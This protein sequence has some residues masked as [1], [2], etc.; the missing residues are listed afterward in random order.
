MN[1]PKVLLTSLWLGLAPALLY[2]QPMAL[3]KPAPPPAGLSSVPVAAQSGIYATLGRDDSHY[4]VRAVG[5]GFHADNPQHALAADFTAQGLE[6]RIGK[7]RWVLALRAYGYGNS[8]RSVSTAAPQASANR[9]EYRRGAL[10]EWYVNGPVGL[11]QG[12]TLNEPPGR[13]NGQ[14]LTITAALS[15]DLTVAVEQDGKALMMAK[16]DGHAV[17]RYTGLTAYDAKGRELR[18]W[19][20]LRGE[21][22]LVRVDDSDAHYPLVIDPFVQRAKLTASDGAANDNF[23]ISVGV[24]ADGNT[25]VA[26]SWHANA[27]QGA[28]YLFVKPAS[29]WATTTETAKLTASDG[30]TNDFFGFSVALSGDS[31]TVVVGAFDA[32]TALGS[33]GAGYVFVK[34]ASGWVTTTETAKLTASDGAGGDQFGGSVAVSGAGDTIVGGAS[35]AKIGSNANQGAAYLFVKP[36][37]GWATTTETAKL[38][39]SDGAANDFFGSSAA[40]IGDGSTAVVGAQA[41]I[42]PIQG[43]G[44]GYVFVKPASGWVTTTETAKLTASDGAKNDGFGSSVAVNGDGNTMV[45]GA[46]DA[47]LG[48]NSGQGAAYV[49]I[50]PVSGWATNMVFTAKLTAS[51]GT[52][53]DRFGITVAVSGDGNT[54][55]VGAL[56]ASVGSNSSQGAAYLFVKPASGWATTTE[57][58]KLTASDGAANDS[59]GISVGISA[60]GNTA[61]V[62]SR[63]ATIGS[64][65]SQGAAY[66]FSLNQAATTTTLASSAN[67]STFGQS[68][69]FTA[70][71]SSTAGTPTGTVTFKDG[72]STLGTGTLNGSAQ[73]A[74]SIAALTAGTHT[75]TAAY[76]GDTNF[77]T[78]TSG[79]LTQTVNQASTTTTLIS[80]PNPSFV[81]QSVTFT[82]TVSSSTGAIAT[83]TVTFRRGSTVLGTATLN[84]AGQATFATSTL[85]AGNH[86]ASAVYAGSA[87]F[88]RST[89]TSITQVVQKNPT[90]T[91]LTSSLNPSSKGQTVSFTASVSS[92]AGGTPTG[93]VTFKNGSNN[94]GSAT[95]DALGQAT[96]STSLLQR[97]THNI[98]SKYHGDANFASSTSATLVQTVN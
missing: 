93:T 91:S 34:P 11:E 87:N 18:S 19:L 77:T 55:L 68:V 4:Q 16:P 46:F 35:G 97:G 95:L 31:S 23:G 96:F 85:R 41:T 32:S 14:P 52:A 47:T 83:G 36:A 43:Q 60:G 86:T 88:A 17:L 29:G 3:R 58:A 90:T 49:F 42:G 78:S 66:V 21:T 22:L 24:S 27:N 40:I 71:V 74:F 80:S 53:G 89:S 2:A 84:G 75:I 8:L 67:P 15:G 62:G 1:R 79:A 59:F 12:F 10:M 9:V 76:G 98:T 63:G 64:N 69:T 13:A 39:A 65:S 70:T 33:K 51:D 50:K 20:E 72:T 56:F 57:T 92:S 94:L 6:V 37:S 81:G 7:A 44:A 30:A 54:A 26:G 73:A 25:V 28:A 5:D 82:A 61:V 48:S 38:T 45:V